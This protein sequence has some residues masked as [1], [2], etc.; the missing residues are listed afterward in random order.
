MQKV[1][2]S[3]PF[4][5]SSRKPRYGG[6]LSFRGTRRG[7]VLSLAPLAVPLSFPKRERTSGCVPRRAVDAEFRGGDPNGSSD[8]RLRRDAAGV[9]RGAKRPVVVLVLVGIR[10]GEPEHRQVE[11]VALAEVGRDR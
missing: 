9:C 3:S 1:E 2:G 11:G 8:A 5:R 6:V 10:L 7:D 4:S